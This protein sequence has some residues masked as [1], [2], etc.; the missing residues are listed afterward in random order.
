[1]PQ[2]RI[3]YCSRAY[4][5]RWFKN[6]KRQSPQLFEILQAVIEEIEEKDGG[7]IVKGEVAR[8]V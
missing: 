6:L 1:M 5:E 4:A 2:S 7:D 8:F 3:T